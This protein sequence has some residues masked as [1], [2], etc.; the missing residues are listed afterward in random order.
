MVRIAMCDMAL[1]DDGYTN[2][3][4][5]DALLSFDKYPDIMTLG[6]E[7]NQDPQIFDVVVTNLPFGFLMGGEIEN[8]IKRFELG[9]GK[10]SVPLEILGLERCLQ[11]LKPN[12][13]MVIVLQDGVL[14]DTGHDFVRTWLHT[15]AEVVAIINLPDHTFTPYRASPKTSVIF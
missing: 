1:Q 10:K 12:G 5:T 4:C 6:G 13:R 2:I 15:Q 14:I 7:N 9:K 3:R 11:F 8:I